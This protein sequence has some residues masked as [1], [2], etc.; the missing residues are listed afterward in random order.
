M[1]YMVNCSVAL[2]PGGGRRAGAAA[3]RET[4]GKFDVLFILDPPAVARLG[5]RVGRES[6]IGQLA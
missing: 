1:I 4:K 3:G 5:R 6:S 2:L